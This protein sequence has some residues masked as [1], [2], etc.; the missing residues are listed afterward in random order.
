MIALVFSGTLSLFET[1]GW[2]IQKT[3]GSA[4]PMSAFKPNMVERA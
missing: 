1:A 3:L 4:V 2:V